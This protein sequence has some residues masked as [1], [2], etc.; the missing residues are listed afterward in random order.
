M[1]NRKKVLIC[2]LAMGM[3]ISDR[4]FSK[5]PSSAEPGQ[6]LLHPDLVK[7][8]YRQYPQ[9]AFWFTSPAMQSG[10]KTDFLKVLD[11]A[12]YL[13]LDKNKYHYSVIVEGLYPQDSAG[14]M[15]QDILFTDAL[16]AYSKDVYQGADISRW[17]SNDEVSGKF[18]AEDDAFLLKEIFNYRA[19]GLQAMYASFEPKEPEYQLLKIELKNQLANNNRLA[20]NQLV[21]CL[22]L[23][24]WIHHFHFE[25]FV[26]V[27]IP[28][29]TLRYFEKDEMK[30]QMKV[31]VGKP[32]TKSPRFSTWCYEVVLY[33]YW[34]VPRSIALNEILPHVKKNPAYLE[35]MNMQVLDKNGRV[36]RAGIDW[37]KYT[38][39][40]L[41]YGFRQCTGCENALGVIKFNLT[42]PFSV[43][44]HDT[45]FKPAFLKNTRFLSHGCIR[46]EK[47]IELGNYLLNNKL[48]S[49]FLKAC[50]KGHDPI[51]VTLKNRVPVFV[52]Y[53]PAE[54][55]GDTVKL[56]KDIYRLFR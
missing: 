32:S 35:T 45:N 40:N 1:L 23:Y 36:V 27:N 55:A 51:S 7:Q 13:G 53:M 10:I 4:A 22:N 39:N 38:R 12:I 31:V 50:I 5:N 14:I 24:R 21:A 20:V 34:N 6:N 46:V 54:V 48:D 43:Y 9:G 52:V 15:K 47:P 16:I 49:N 26:V 28:A 25:K 8:F 29:A 33:P 41:P 18:M 56:Y 11:N 37:S 19:N 44:L 2:M 17:I 30:L 3:I 42:D